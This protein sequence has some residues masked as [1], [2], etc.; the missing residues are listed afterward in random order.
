MESVINKEYSKSES[1]ADI[2]QN[3]AN[4]IAMNLLNLKN[5]KKDNNQRFK[6]N[7]TRNDFEFVFIIGKGGFGKVWRVKYK[8]T[9][10]L[11]ALKEMS[12]TKIIDK[13][14]ENSI[15]GEREFLSFLHHP[16][17]VNMH[18]AFQDNDNLYLVMDLL[19]GGDLRYHC[20]RYR[21]FSE[22][23]TRF[24]LA[25]IIHSLSYI[26]KNNVIHRDIKPENLV[27][28]DKGYVCI[29]D[30]GVA[31]KNMKD[32]SS[33]TSGTPG[34]MCPEVMNGKNH[35]FPAD[36]FSIGVIGYEFM[37]GKRP[38]RGRGRKE[39][40]E[41]MMN[42]QARITEE[43]MK[44]GW[45]IECVEFI[46]ALLERKEKRR[47]GYKEGVKELKQ[48]PWMKYY[49]WKDLAKK[50][51]PAPFIPENMDNFD[52]KYCESV[53]EISDETQL[54]YDEIILCTHYNTAFSDFYFD[55]NEAQR[56]EYEYEE[57]EDNE[58]QSEIDEEKKKNN[59]KKESDNI[60]KKREKILAIDNSEKDNKKEADTKNEIAQE[61]IKNDYSKSGSHTKKI[62]DIFEFPDKE[63]KNQHIINKLLDKEANKLN[64][65]MIKKGNDINKKRYILPKNNSYISLMQN[66]KRD[67]LNL[68]SRNDIKKSNDDFINIKKICINSKNAISK[69]TNQN[70]NLDI[71]DKYALLRKKQNKIMKLNNMIKINEHIK[72]SYNVNNHDINNNSNINIY[73]S[74]NLFN[75]MINNHFN[76]NKKK[77]I[78]ERNTI[79]DLLNKQKQLIMNDNKKKSV[80][81]YIK[82]ANQNSY[83]NKRKNIKQ[84]NKINRSNSVGLLLN[85]NLNYGSNKIK[86]YS[87][88]SLVINN[89]K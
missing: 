79:Q 23:Q 11:Y 26:H 64:I 50:N 21:S 61:L 37:M 88:N 56:K 54:R 27:L 59:I 9:N 36:Y 2:N 40:K 52:K 58:S 4:N 12:K 80:D 6:S 74:I 5:T 19:T 42:Y 55:K 25:C 10:E 18:F 15:N 28:D 35:S 45:S 30:F 86:Q 81:N 76:I 87:L 44:D 39:I 63:K 14:S 49:P 65:L 20:S 78:N 60:I 69:I 3:R 7:L 41:Q 31:K 32:N 24:F 38:Y 84:N 16:F 85:N 1:N 8:K 73:L 13:K 43:E 72:N 67:K 66:S 71:K 57:T 82:Y 53:D 48:H 29:T 22:E 47:L 51:L 33:E 75:K 17:I 77:N 62:N 34:Y 46:N 68:I 89:H 83:F 70:S